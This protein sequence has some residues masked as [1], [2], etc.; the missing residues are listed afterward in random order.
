MA[1]SLLVHQSKI[2]VYYDSPI[3]TDPLES[4]NN[5]IKTPQRQAHG[6]RDME[7]FKL[8]IMPQHEAK[9]SLSG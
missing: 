4:T 3:S 8:K 5:K 1:N 6:F 9:Y 7:F 2:L